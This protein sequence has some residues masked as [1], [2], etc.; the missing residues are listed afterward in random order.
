MGWGT[1]PR[2]VSYVEFSINT[3]HAAQIELH[4][5]IPGLSVKNINI[6]DGCRKSGTSNSKHHDL[7]FPVTVKVAHQW[8]RER[9]QDSVPCFGYIFPVYPE[10]DI[11]CH[12]LGT[13]LFFRN[14][15]NGRIVSRYVYI[16]D[17]RNLNVVTSKPVLNR[18]GRASGLDSRS[19][20]NKIPVYGSRSL[21]Y[22]I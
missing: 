1:V 19:K 3:S 10:S 12:L 21:R 15:V 2:A 11:L 7:R 9:L 22:G 20:N 4:K 14:Y 8:N 13:H 16:Q 6:T 17:G 18:Y 5:N